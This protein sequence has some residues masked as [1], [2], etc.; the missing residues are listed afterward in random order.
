MVSTARGFTC[1]L[2]VPYNPT[3]FLQ[4]LSDARDAGCQVVVIYMDFAK[5]FDNL[6][7][8]FYSC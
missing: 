5:A 2:S 1:G 8:A 7:S 3:C 4:E 6:H